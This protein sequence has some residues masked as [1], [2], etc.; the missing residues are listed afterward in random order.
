MGIDSGLDDDI[1]EETD[2]LKEEL[3]NWAGDIRGALRYLKGTDKLFM[4]A[5][6]K[7]G[8]I[9]TQGEHEELI[10]RAHDEG[11]VA[12]YV[13]GSYG[14]AVTRGIGCMALYLRAL[15]GPAWLRALAYPPVAHYIADAYLEITNNPRKTGSNNT[16]VGIVRERF[17]KLSL[18]NLKRKVV[19]QYNA[20]G[21]LSREEALEAA[22]RVAELDD[23]EGFPVHVDYKQ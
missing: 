21:P 11:K 20:R 18:R 1:E 19:E 14:E 9:G 2:K 13:L 4:L 16:L 5:A 23:Q 3:G 8:W 15:H 12:E 22:R 7:L 10:R 17:A 6:Y